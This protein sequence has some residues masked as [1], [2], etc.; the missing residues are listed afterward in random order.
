[1]KKSLLLGAL[2]VSFATTSGYGQSVEELLGITIPA[3]QTP[4]NPVETGHASAEESPFYLRMTAT[5]IFQGSINTNGTGNAANVT[6]NDSKV[7]FDIG[8]G[9]GLTIGY[10]IP[11][12]YIFLEAS[13]GYQWAGV[14]KFTGTYT[15]ANTTFDLDGQN[16]N[17]YQV[18]LMFTPG[19]EFE[20]AGGFP[21]LN[22]GAIRFGP[23]FG[24][25]YQ[26]LNVTE[27]T[28]FNNDT[29]SFGATGWTFSYGAMVSLDFFFDYN[30]AFTMGWQ[31]VCTTGINYGQLDAQGP[32]AAS[33]PEIDSNF[34]YTNVVSVGVSLYF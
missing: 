6:L 25:T 34:T 24:M 33:L 15:A 32:V 21:F 26:D 30:A 17:L 27:I 23:S 14:R 3:V 20:W 31:I 11:E 5:P 12:T 29:F 18:P 4:A 8:I 22:G 9:V 28:G 19:L 2:A 16:G 7:E 10:R 1:M 13:A